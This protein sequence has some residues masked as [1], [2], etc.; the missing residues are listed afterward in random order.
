LAFTFPP[1]QDPLDA[2]GVMI[3]APYARIT[4]LAIDETNSSGRI[5]MGVYRSK[6]ARDANLM[7]FY[8]ALQWPLNAQGIPAR[9]A[10]MNKL[11]T[12]D[13]GVTWQN[14]AGQ[15]VTPA[16]PPFPSLP[17]IQAALTAV[18]NPVGTGYYNL[19]KTLI[20][21]IITGQPEIP[22]GAAP[23]VDT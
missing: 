21:T 20:Y 11:T 23:V 3:A 14:A 2:P 13:G 16:Y 6:G 17:Q 10:E 8:R 12:Q 9:D 18:D 15:T 4:F 1:E 7:N 19:L 22:A 5:V